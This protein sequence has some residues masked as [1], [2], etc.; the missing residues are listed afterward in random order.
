M[1]KPNTAL[2][3]IKGALNFNVIVKI[4]LYKNFFFAKPFYHEAE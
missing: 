4:N 3:L 2:D 1:A